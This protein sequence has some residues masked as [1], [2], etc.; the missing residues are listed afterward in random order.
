V[1]KY[2]RYLA[3][4]VVS[5]DEA[6]APK[7][8]KGAKPKTPRKPKPQSTLSQPPNPKPAPGKP[9]EKKIKVVMDTTEAPSPA[10]RSKAGKVVKKRTLKSSQQLVDEFVDE[11][12]PTDEPKFEDEEADIIQNVMEESLKYAYPA[13]RGPLPPVVIRE[14]EPGKFQPFP[15][16]QG[17]GKEKVGEEQA[18]QALLN[19]QTPK[20]KNH[21]EQFIFQRR[22]PATAEP[23]GLVE[24]LSLYAE[25]GL[26]NSETDSD[27]EV[28]LAMNAEAQEEGQ[29]GTNPGDVGVS[30]TPSS[31]VVYAGPNLDHMDLG[32][33]EASSQPNTEQMDE[34]FTATAYSKVQENLKLPTEGD[35]RLEE[36]ASSAATLSSLQNLDK[37]INFTNQFLAKKSQEDEP[38]KPTLKRKFNLWSW[39]PYIRTPPITTTITTLPPPLPQPQQGISNSIIIQRIGEL[40][41]SIADQVDANQALEERLDKQGNR[42]HQ[43]ETQDLSRMLQ[44]QQR[45][46]D[47]QEID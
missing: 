42:I 31:H 38:E 41:R 20:K 5:D 32:I 30:Q 8:A 12:V 28:T 2:Q 44:E 10:K 37:E 24:T 19:I 46:I 11:G 3:G 26:T 34:E 1:T 47:K 35:V 21:V 16:V 22:T 7:P 33:A 40:E 36:P 9:Q 13:P 25:L 45:I 17:K 15:E 43:L 39:F 27:E 29:G 4:E 18:A 14:P 23:S 6:Q